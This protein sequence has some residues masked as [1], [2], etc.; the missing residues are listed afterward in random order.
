M[1]EN[2]EKNSLFISDINISEKSLKYKI[3]HYFFLK[4]KENKRFKTWMLCFLIIIEAIQLISFA[5][6]SIH[7]NSWKIEGNGMIIVSAIISIFRISP[8][9]SL[10]N[11]NIFSLVLYL[12][13][14]FI[15]IISLFVTIQILF[16]DTSSKFYKYS[17]AIIWPLIDIMTILSR[18][19]DQ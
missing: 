17:S 2:V 10:L 9:V 4:I 15:F 16:Y 13:I 18:E 6:S 14:I 11:K 7:H 3:F 1:N 12:L 5:F 8:F 19:L